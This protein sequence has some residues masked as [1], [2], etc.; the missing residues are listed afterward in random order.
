MLVQKILIHICELH[1][2]EHHKP[3]QQTFYIRLNALRTNIDKHPEWKP[4]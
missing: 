2:F 4:I 3:C 1:L